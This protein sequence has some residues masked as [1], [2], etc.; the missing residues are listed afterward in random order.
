LN[1]KIDF[2]FTHFVSS[3][4]RQFYNGKHWQ[5]APARA[6][7]QLVSRWGLAVPLKRLVWGR[8]SLWRIIAGGRM[9]RAFVFVVSIMCLAVQAGLNLP[10]SSPYPELIDSL[11]DL[12]EILEETQHFIQPVSPPSPEVFIDKKRIPY[13]V[14]WSGFDKNVTKYMTA[15][16]DGY[17][18]PRY[19][20]LIWEDLKTRERVI[21]LVSTGFELARIPA[22]IYYQPEAFYRGML[23]KGASYDSA[24]R[25]VFDPAHSAVAIELIPESLYSAYEQNE[26]ESSLALAMEPIAMTLTG[27]PPPDDSSG[28]TGAVAFATGSASNA[29]FVS[30]TADSNSVVTMTIAIP[31]SFGGEHVEIFSKDNLVYSLNWLI[32]KSWL[33]T[34]GKPNVSW[35]D[36]NTGSMDARF[37]IVSDADDDADGDGYSRLRE[38][39]FEN[40]DP[41]SFDFR[42]VDGD[43]MH[44]WYEMKLFGSMEQCGT[45][46]FDGDGLWNNVEMVF[47]TGTPATV[48]ILSDPS[49]QDS[50]ADGMDD[51]LETV[52]YPYLEPMNPNDADYDR[53][54]ISNIDE[55]MMGTSITNCDTD[56]DTLTDRLEIEWGT[57]PLNPDDL[58]SD[59]DLDGLALSNE[60]TYGTSPFLDDTDGDGANDSLEVSQGSSPT[61]PDD[62]GLE[63]V[64]DDLVE[65]DIDLIA[66]GNDSERY[67]LTISGERTLRLVSRDYGTSEKL[68]AVLR[69]GQTYTINLGHVGTSPEQIQEYGLPDY[70]YEVRFKENFGQSPNLIFENVDEM[71]GKH[72]SGSP[73]T[74]GPFDNGGELNAVV[75]TPKITLSLSKDI[76]SLKHD[77]LCGLSITTEPPGIVLENH[78]YE[79]A[80]AAKRY[81]N[82]IGNGES[83]TWTNNIAGEFVIRA[84]ADF[85]G[86]TIR[87]VEVP[88][89]VLFPTRAQILADSVILS[90]M[91]AKWQE[92]LSDSTATQC[93]EHGFMVYLN[94]FSN[95]YFTAFHKEGA[96]SPP[97]TSASVYLEFRDDPECFPNSPGSLYQV[98]SF[99]THPPETYSPTNIYRHTGPSTSFDNPLMLQMTG[100]FQDLYMTIPLRTCIAVI[101][102]QILHTFMNT[103]Q[104]ERFSHEK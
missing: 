9:K 23:L 44:D 90:E 61:N 38:I 24:M 40:T 60:Y 13:P 43:G 89:T 42:D 97:G 63:P 59:M 92:T 71:F 68:A 57:D 30:M 83:V 6:R 52:T 62:G 72:K 37:Y 82:P 33:P 3:E 103:A 88:A 41:A 18:L 12:V 56:G 84:K 101:P 70:D 5:G 78:R 54:G 94:T 10:N 26:I 4:N 58:G 29:P 34:Y 99:H 74:P 8:A 77:N 91:N 1:L 47:S 81:W 53:D 7:P 17:G 79:A 64:I 100:G 104:T 45:N 73:T 86:N 16:M 25:W 2:A 76:M 66:P 87:S 80:F 11:D 21:T 20:L 50:D 69:K 55:I 48:T 19:E 65:V 36:P 39:L 96:W 35:T 46:D 49:L 67:R 15:Y 85:D 95:G 75:H 14:D 102:K 31:E 93:R 98:A 32:A 27:P 51:F 28:G 22:P